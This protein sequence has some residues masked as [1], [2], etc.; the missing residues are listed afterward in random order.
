MFYKDSTILCYFEHPT[1][2]LTA[3]QAVTQR[4]WRSKSTSA[5]TACLLLSLIA[6]S[7]PGQ[8]STDPSALYI[9]PMV[10]DA[11]GIHPGCDP[12]DCSTDCD[13]PCDYGC[14]IQ[15]AS[16]IHDVL[17]ACRLCVLCLSCRD[18]DWRRCADG[19]V[20]YSV[21]ECSTLSHTVSCGRAPCL[22]LFG[23][24]LLC[25]KL[26]SNDACKLGPQL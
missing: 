26:T 23:C 6:A 9:L 17:H 3:V 12:L 1:Q 20:Y 5:R 22:L 11:K 7:K 8:R 14:S 15:G 10:Q 18:H 4:Q 2:C 21:L 25:L 24:C 19:H 16:L 13:T